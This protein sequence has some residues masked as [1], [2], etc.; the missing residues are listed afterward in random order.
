MNKFGTLVLLSLFMV[1]MSLCQFSLRDSIV[2]IGTGLTLVFSVGAQN[3]LI[4]ED[5]TLQS[6]SERKI[7]DSSR[8]VE[9]L[10]SCS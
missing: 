1:S 7:F 5:K 3:R 10:N 2:K 4:V 6:N 9:M 8:C